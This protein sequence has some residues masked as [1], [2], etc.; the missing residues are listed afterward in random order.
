VSGRQNYRKTRR[1]S[2]RGATG[3]SETRAEKSKTDNQTESVNPMTSN[4]QRQPTNTPRQHVPR[5]PTTDAARTATPATVQARSGPAP[6][7]INRQQQAE[8]E[9]ITRAAQ[10]Q[11]AAARNRAL[12]TSPA[13]PA[14]PVQ[15]E[16]HPQ[17]QML[18]GPRSDE[19]FERHMQ[20]M[21][22]AGNPILTPNLSD[23]DFRSGGEVVNVD[24]VPFVMHTDESRKGVIRFNGIGNLPTK[25]SVG[26][27]EDAELPSREELGDTDQSLWELDRYNNQPIDPWQSEVVVPI[28]ST[29]PDG[30]IYELASRSPT[31]LFAIRGLLDRVHRHPQRTKGLVPIVT[32]KIGT[33]PNRKFGRDM[34]K[35][36]YQ[37]I[38]WCEKDGSAPAK[39]PDPIS[40]GPDGGGT[41][42]GGQA[43]FNDKI[44]F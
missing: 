6:A 23:G 36:V 31:A 42:T 13:S 26:L 15:V 4:F 10:E 35:P 28:V 22:S 40:S 39:K 3:G 17:S 2:L 34:F 38:G 33:Y 37:I 18:T 21:G 8:A 44:P 16:A 32:M 7:E 12:A 29:A 19:A 30:T 27:Y 24:G 14:T 43:E 25:I 5:H 1:R 11:Q 41:K 20:E 9:Q